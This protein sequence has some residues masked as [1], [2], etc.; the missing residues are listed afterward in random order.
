[1]EGCISTTPPLHQQRFPKGDGVSY[2]QTRRTIWDILDRA[3]ADI[4]QDL[5][6]ELKA[7]W[8][9]IKPKRPEETK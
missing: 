3:L 8:T 4:D 6:P 1:M 5:T 9:E 2:I 7:K